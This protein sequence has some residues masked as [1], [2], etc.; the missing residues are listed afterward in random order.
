[1]RLPWDESGVV[2]R[3]LW[4]GDNELWGHRVDTSMFCGQERWDAGTAFF[5][6]ALEAAQSAMGDGKHQRRQ[7]RLTLGCAL[8]Q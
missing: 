1:M 4:L 7:F 3:Q 5:C 2:G 8:Q 6:A